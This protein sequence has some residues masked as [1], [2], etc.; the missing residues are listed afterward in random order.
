MVIPSY[1]PDLISSNYNVCLRRYDSPWRF[2]KERYSIGNKSPSF[3]KRTIASAINLWASSRH[4]FV[5][6]KNGNIYPKEAAFAG[7]VTCW[8]CKYIR[9][10][11]DEV[12][13]KESGN[14]GF[15]KE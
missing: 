2:K 10:E 12:Q 13:V 4:L 3:L 8:H 1:W 6:V 9:N 5:H 14:D 15:P 11:F 7:S